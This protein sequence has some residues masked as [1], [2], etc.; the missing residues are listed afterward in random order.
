M[1]MRLGSLSAPTRSGANSVLI[2]RPLKARLL[3]RCWRALAPGLWLL[4]SLLL[5][6]QPAWRL[7]GIGRF[8]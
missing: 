5:R 1:T 2:R 4:G 7:T 3:R 6:A 8:R